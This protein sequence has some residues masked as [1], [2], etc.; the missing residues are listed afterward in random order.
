[1]KVEIRTHELK[2]AN[3]ELKTKQEEILTQNEEIQ[4]QAEELAT[5][6]DALEQ[7]NEEIKTKNEQISKAYDNIRVLSEFGQKVSATLS[8]EAINDMIYNYVNSLMDIAA[9][10]IG[11]LNEKKQIIEYHS[12]FEQGKKLPYFYKNMKSNNSLNVWCL[13][14]RK[15]VYINNIEKEFNK[16]IDSI[17]EF[18]TLFKPYSVIQLPL[19]VENRAI[20]VITVNSDKKNAY[21]DRD[22][23]NLQSLASY[24][25]I[26]LDNAHVYEIVNKQNLHIKSS[27]EYAKTIQN[28]ILPIDKNLKKYFETF[29]IYRPRDIVS[30]DF[31]WFTTEKD[32]GGKEMVYFAVVDCTGHG[33]PGA[34]MSLIGSR[35]LNEIVNEKKIL[36]PSQI[37]EFL[38]VGIQLSLRQDETDNNDGMDIC[39]CRL[40]KAENE[41]YKLIFSGAK[42]PLYIYNNDNTS[43]ERISGAR[44]SIGGIRAKRSKLFYTNYETTV[45]KG[46]ILYLSSDGY[47]DQNAPDRKKLGSLRLK[48]LLEE[49]KNLQLNS[50]KQRL[51][52]EL[53]Q[54]MQKEEQRDDITFIGLE[55]I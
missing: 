42:R 2:E 5:Q 4:Q 23:T 18:K 28:S 29:I 48:Q 12:F 10:G 38:N 1:R 55:L 21:T 43:I 44:K 20:G 47:V 13:K 24:I 11:L 19:I 36:N 22:I 8:V 51:E 34:F 17:P 53:E 46:D 45:K 39:L 31:Y 7:Q 6:R 41:K 30:G 50:Q 35:L 25:S 26:A 14:N 27:I 52:H 37:L 16:Y 9:F 3:A 32:K 15:V 49:I 40:Q 54:H 33:V